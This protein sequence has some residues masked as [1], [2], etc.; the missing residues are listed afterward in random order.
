LTRWI[1]REHV[2]LKTSKYDVLYDKGMTFYDELGL[3][4]TAGGNQTERS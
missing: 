2:L 1:W 3:Y 4:I